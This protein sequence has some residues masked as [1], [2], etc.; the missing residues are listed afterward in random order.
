MDA[1]TANTI[2]GRAPLRAAQTLRAAI[3]TRKGKAGAISYLYSPKIDRDIVVVSDLE[4][5]HVLHLEADNNVKYFDIDIDR[6]VA[7][8][9]GDGYQGTRPDARVELRNGRMELVEV[10]YQK[11]LDDDLRTQLQVAAQQRYAKQIGAYW[12]TYTEK[13]FED[14]E[15]LI[16]DWM[17][18]VVVLG[19]TR[20]KVLPSLLADVEH[21]VKEKTSQTLEQLCRKKMGPWDLAF[22]ATFRLIQQGKLTSNLKEKPLSWNT[23]VRPWR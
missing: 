11:D 16:H 4:L 8:L 13:D 6:V 10:K 19:E 23:V 22:S 21:L 9:D 18:I 14:E 17:H 2:K 7:Y 5:A 3:R 1:K 15:R 20:D 12:R